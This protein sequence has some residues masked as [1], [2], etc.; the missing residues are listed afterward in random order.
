PGQNSAAPPVW[1]IA[2][3]P[4]NVT[5]PTV[6]AVSADGKTVFTVTPVLVRENNKDIPKFVVR[7]VVNGEKNHDGIVNAP[8]ALAGPPVLLGESLLIPAADGFVYRHVPGT[9]RLNPDMLVAGPP[10][11]G[12]RRS[13]D[14]VCC[15]T[16]L[17]DGAFLVS[18][19][20]KK[21]TRWEWPASGKW[22]QGGTWELSERPAGP[23]L[24][25]PAGAGGSPRL[26]I[27]D[28]TGS[29]W[30]YP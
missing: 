5:S 27:A 18:D 8:A 22:N 29:V 28:V 1:G 10:W 30:L 17:S 14:A 21:L 11:A 23:G 16:P 9:G 12:E 13:A 3:A 19:G 26:L 20:S 25:L 6:V 24:L 7:R 4:V 2:D 15:L